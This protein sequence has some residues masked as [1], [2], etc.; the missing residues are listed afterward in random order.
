MAPTHVALPTLMRCTFIK[1]SPT[2]PMT[3]PFDGPPVTPCDPTLGYIRTPVPSITP[4]LPKPNN[5][6]KP[7]K[8]LQQQFCSFLPPWQRVLYGS[9]CKAYSTNTLYQH[10]LDMTPI[11]I[12]S[13]ASVQNN[14]Q[15]G[16]TWVIAKEATPL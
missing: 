3:L 4:E 13:N 6:D 2:V 12:V 1:F 8:T 14:G 9:L 15:S 5:F 7:Y 16:F 11:M 10:L